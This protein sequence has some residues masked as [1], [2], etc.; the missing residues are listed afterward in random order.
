MSFNWFQ[1]VSKMFQGFLWSFRGFQDV[2]ESFILRSSKSVRSVTP[3]K[4]GVLRPTKLL[5]SKNSD[6]GCKKLEKKT[7]SDCK[8]F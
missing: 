7:V 4:S 2:S 6:L 1:G 8:P 5:W 3:P